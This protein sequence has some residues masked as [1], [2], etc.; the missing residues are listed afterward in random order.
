MITSAEKNVAKNNGGLT[1][2]IS[3]NN[4]YKKKSYLLV[5]KR[6]PVIYLL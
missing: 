5:A 2:D 3:K 6:V 4:Q 1:K